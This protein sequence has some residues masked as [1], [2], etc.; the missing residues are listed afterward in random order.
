MIWIMLAALAALIYGVIYAVHS[1]KAGKKTPA[2]GA[3]LLSAMDAVIL[4]YVLVQA[5]K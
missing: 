5:F 1:F 3:V 4:T 2:F